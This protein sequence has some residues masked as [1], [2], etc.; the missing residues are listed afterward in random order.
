[1]PSIERITVDGCLN[2]IAPEV[3]LQQLF[4]YHDGCWNFKN[5]AFIYVGWETRYWVSQEEHARLKSSGYSFSTTTVG[6]NKG[7]SVGSSKYVDRCLLNKYKYRVGRSGCWPYNIYVELLDYIQEDHH[8]P[9]T[10]QND[11]PKLAT[12]ARVVDFFHWIAKVNKI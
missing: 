5:S 1:M 3:V 4:D 11:Y 7:P 12:P 6:W 10:Q 9:F 8:L 2:N